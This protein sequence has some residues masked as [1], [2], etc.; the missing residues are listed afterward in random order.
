MKF[1]ELKS[2]PVAELQKMLAESR[3]QLREL[4]FKT[5]SGQL[6]NVREIRIV[7]QTI[8]RVLMLLRVHNN[9]K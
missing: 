7:R 3:Q 9:Q 5:A 6:K 1:Q 8:A 4:K 2:K